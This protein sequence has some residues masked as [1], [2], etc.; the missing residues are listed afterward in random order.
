MEESNKHINPGDCIVGLD[1]G[2]TKISVMI[3]RKNQYGKLEILGTGRSVSIGVSRGI[4][5]NIDQTVTSIK[6]A[7]KESNLK[8]DA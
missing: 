3:G 5:A 7:L 6:E 2:T 1:I 4:V 8:R